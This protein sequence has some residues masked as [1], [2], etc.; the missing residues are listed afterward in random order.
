[1][2][3]TFQKSP[4]FKATVDVYLRNKYVGFISERRQGRF[5]WYLHE[6][7]TGLTGIEFSLQAAIDTIKMMIK[8]E[9]QAKPIEGEILANN[10]IITT[11]LKVI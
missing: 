6:P 7:A 2:N 10:V 3:I 11:E 9:H 5:T 8:R 1:M 4:M